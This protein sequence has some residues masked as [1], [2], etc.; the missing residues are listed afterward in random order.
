MVCIF[1]KAIMQKGMPNFYEYNGQKYSLNFPVHW[2]CNHR[3]GTGPKECW[4]CKTYGC[5]NG[6]FKQYCINCRHNQYVD[7]P[8]NTDEFCKSQYDYMYDDGFISDCTEEAMEEEGIGCNKC[9]SCVTGGAG[10]CV[11]EL[12]LAQKK[13]SVSCNPHD[14]ICEPNENDSHDHD[15]VYSPT[16][17]Q[18]IEDDDNYTSSS[19]VAPSY[20]V[21]QDIYDEIN[22][23][24]EAN[25]PILDIVYDPFEHGI[26]AGLH[27]YCGELFD[28]DV[29]YNS[30]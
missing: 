26:G 4:N 11:L 15:K 9:Y 14:M 19:S 6:I 5:D 30:Y 22:R 24:V 23:Y 18:T 3:E 25:N 28:M 17:M 12:E 1:Y 20:D 27:Q 16:S 29:G 2:A 7:S 13:T 21:E 8:R 10:P